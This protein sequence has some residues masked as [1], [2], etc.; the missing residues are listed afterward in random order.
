[1]A[2][3]DMCGKETELFEVKVETSIMKTCGSCAAF[4]TILK[5]PAQKEKRFHRPQKKFE[6]PPEKVVADFSEKVRK[7]RE[8]KNMTQKD[9]AKLIAEKESLVHKME[10]KGFRPSVYLAKKL[11]K[12]FKITL[13]EL[14]ETSEHAS[15]KPSSDGFTLG[16]FI[17]TK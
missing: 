14:D 16:D 9:F 17:K 8:S 10:S 1:M 7:I 3:C 11:Q 12:M 5:R 15:K 6:A 2:S 4:G 13:I